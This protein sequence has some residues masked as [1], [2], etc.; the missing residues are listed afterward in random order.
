M[1]MLKLPV[2]ENETKSKNAWAYRVTGTKHAGYSSSPDLV[3]RRAEAV[4]R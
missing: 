3:G 4:A 2:N 1:M